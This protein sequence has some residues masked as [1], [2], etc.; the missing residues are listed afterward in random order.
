ME[1][2]NIQRFLTFFVLLAIIPVISFANRQSLSPVR[3]SVYITSGADTIAPTNG[4]QERPAV[5]NETRVIKKVPKS[6]RQIKPLPVPGIP[7]KPVIK[8]K[9]IKPVIGVK[10]L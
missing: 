7:V 4:S 9:I 5:S 10:G 1:R 3:P 8:P 2:I 6:R